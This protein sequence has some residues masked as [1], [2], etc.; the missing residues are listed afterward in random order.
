MSRWNTNNTYKYPVLDIDVG[1]VHIVLLQDGQGWYQANM[2]IFD[3]SI[4]KILGTNDE[5]VAKV[6]AEA[7]AIEEL[8]RRLEELKETRMQIA[9][10]KLKL[11]WYRRRSLK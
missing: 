8:G 5:E 1:R 3:R 4:I 11:H 9:S 2:S 6:K 10:C 7:L